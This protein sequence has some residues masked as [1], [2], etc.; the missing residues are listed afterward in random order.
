MKWERSEDD[1]KMCKA[2]EQVAK[3]VGAKSIQAGL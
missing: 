1:R 2:L 3:E